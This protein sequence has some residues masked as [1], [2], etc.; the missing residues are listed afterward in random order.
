MLSLARITALVLLFHF[1]ATAAQ[2]AP[3]V[4][5]SGPDHVAL[6]E[7]YTSEGC[8]SCPAADAW[9]SNLKNDERLWR[10]IVPIAFHVDY[11]DRLGWADPFAAAAFSQRQYD[12][13]AQWQSDRIYTPA[14]V[15]DGR[16]WR[17]YFARDALPQDVPQ[18]AGDLHITL[19]DSSAIISFSAAG[20]RYENLHVHLALLG[21][22]LKSAVPRG[23]NKGKVLTHDFVV[24]GYET[25]TLA[26]D[27]KHHHNTAALPTS[28]VK[29]ER[30]ASAAWVTRGNDLTPIQVVGGWL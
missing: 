13:A 27:G 22:D 2:D 28:A 19:G 20:K 6:L 10:P 18:V 17:G 30:R 11:W 16:E 8:S 7:L 23:E 3:R 15:F 12:Y 9:M 5:K 1:S 21:F 29:A 24:L 25:A 4:L 14:F 26:H